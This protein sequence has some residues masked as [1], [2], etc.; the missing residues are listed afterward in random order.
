MSSLDGQGKCQIVRKKTSLDFGARSDQN[1]TDIR[2]EVTS[3]GRRANATFPEIL[4][5]HGFS[6]RRCTQVRRFFMY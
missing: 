2:R 6:E 4:L 5:D 3:G 1:Q